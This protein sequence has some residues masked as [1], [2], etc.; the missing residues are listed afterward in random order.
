VPKKKQ[1]AEGPIAQIVF[2]LPQDLHD[3]LL[4]AAAGL[5]LDLSNL[6]R[7]MI[8]EHV[9]EYIERGRRAAAALEHARAHVQQA[10][11]PEQKLGGELPGRAFGRRRGSILIDAG[12]RQPA[13]PAGGAGP[14]S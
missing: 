8:A 6:L 7:M 5:G 3:A 1:A 13:S 14:K 9:A 12:A 10:A 11:A 4:T 2:R